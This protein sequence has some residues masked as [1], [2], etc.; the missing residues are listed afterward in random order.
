VRFI[1][2]SGSTA[3]EAGGDVGVAEADDGVFTS[4][5]RSEQCEVVWTEG[6]EAGVD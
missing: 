4:H 5:D 2:I 1:A 6:T 3:I